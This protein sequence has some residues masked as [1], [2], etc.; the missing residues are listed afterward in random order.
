MGPFSIKVLR[1]T[2][3]LVSGIIMVQKLEGQ[4]PHRYGKVDKG[5]STEDEYDAD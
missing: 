1:L 2:W 5:I 4:F 3:L